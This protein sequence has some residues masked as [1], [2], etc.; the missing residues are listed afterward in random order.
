MTDTEIKLTQNDRLQLFLMDFE[1]ALFT[2]CTRC[3]Q[4]IKKDWSPQKWADKLE[5][6]IKEGKEVKN[7]VRDQ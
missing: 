3:R 2:R 6:L 5:T 7:E 1:A 4:L